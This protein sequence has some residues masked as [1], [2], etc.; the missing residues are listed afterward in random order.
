MDDPYALFDLGVRYLDGNDVEKDLEKAF[1]YFLEAAKGNV[2]VAQYNVGQCYEQGLGVRQNFSEALRWYEIAAENGDNDALTNLGIY[3]YNGW[4]C[5]VNY[6]KAVACWTNVFLS[7]FAGAAKAIFNLGICYRDGHGVERNLYIAEYLFRKAAKLGHDKAPIALTQIPPQNMLFYID[8]KKM[9]FE[10]EVDDFFEEWKR[11]STK[12]TNYRSETQRYSSWTETFIVEFVNDVVLDLYQHSS[13]P[14]IAVSLS[15]M[16]INGPKEYRTVGLDLLRR[17]AQ[18]SL[19]QPNYYWDTQRG[20]Y[21][22]V[23]TLWEILYYLKT[24]DLSHLDFGWR[25][26]DCYSEK[27]KSISA[28][29]N[30]LFLLYLTRAINMD[31]SNPK[32]VEYLSARADF[33]MDCSGTFMGVLWENGLH[34]VEWRPHY[35]S[36]KRL[37]YERAEKLGMGAAFLDRLNESRMMY[38]YGSIHNIQ[39]ENGFSEID[40]TWDD[41]TYQAKDRID[42]AMNF[43]FKNS[44]LEGKISFCDK[45]IDMIFESLSKRIVSREIKKSRKGD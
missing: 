38:T 28:R 18:Q 11:N 13:H 5:E 21:G 26:S 44:F 31:E 36:D 27:K 37:C 15:R 3:Y 14:L 45:E 6:E 24:E 33:A 2:P 19:K 39:G 16:C 9:I 20:V 32:T 17:A 42:Y 25:L 10:Q 43:M 35:I 12:G 29:L 7:N 41:I 8:E 1:D 40:C 23:D 4:G 22:C 34:G 30:S